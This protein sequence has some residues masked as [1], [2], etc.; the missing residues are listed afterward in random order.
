MSGMTVRPTLKWVRLAYTVWFLIAF[1]LV[2]VCN[3]YWEG[4][5]LEWVALAV[6]ALWLVW[7]FRLQ[8]RRRMTKLIIEEDRLRLEEGLLSKTTRT[9]Q[10]SKIQDIT[11]RQTLV[12]RLWRLGDLSLETAAD[13]GGLLI[14]NLDEPQALA[15]QIMDL[16]RGQ[17]AQTKRK[18]S[19]S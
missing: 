2:L 11:V 9:L 6:G 1:V 3:N 10:L 4:K 15:D 19:K 14:R 5:H 18:E 12:Q 7:P 17:Q 13:S 8:I 16:V